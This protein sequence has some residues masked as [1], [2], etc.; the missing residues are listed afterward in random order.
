MAEVGL[1]TVGRGLS[2]NLKSPQLGKGCKLSVG[3]GWGRN[4]LK[5]KRS[6]LVKG[7]TFRIAD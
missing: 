3:I 7:R 4:Q 1:G 6:E 2:K 5:L